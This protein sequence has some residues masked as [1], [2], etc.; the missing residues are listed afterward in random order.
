MNPIRTSTDPLR[1]L[2]SWYRQA[3]AAR[4]PQPD[5]MTL[6]TASPTGKPSARV[7]LYK[8]VRGSGAKR[9]IFF[10]SNYQSR[11]G[12]ELARNK[13]A[14][15]VFV[16][17]IPERQIRVEGKVTR[18][19]AR[20]SDVY[21]AQR[22]RDSQLSAWVSSQSRE[23]KS[24]ASLQKALRAATKRFDGKPIPRPAHWGGYCLLPQVIEF[25][26]GRPHR[27]HERAQY[28]RTARG[29]KRVLLA[30]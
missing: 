2:E 17:L 7:V 6:A 21:W 22:S 5:A 15:L 23:I 24:Y 25:W 3:K 30:P 9:K 1:A 13:N 10:V 14:A 18:A 19:S 11:K 27:L 26:Q 4:Y 28:K 12:R 8:G 20:E 16:W 29:W